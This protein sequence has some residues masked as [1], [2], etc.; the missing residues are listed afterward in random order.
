MTRFFSFA[1][2]SYADAIDDAD[3]RK[4]PSRERN[5]QWEIS[6]NV[7]VTINSMQGGLGSSLGKD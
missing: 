3:K 4:V 7:E 1:C 2:I 5:R 6:F